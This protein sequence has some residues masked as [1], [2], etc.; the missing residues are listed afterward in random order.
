MVVFARLLVKLTPHRITVV[1]ISL[2]FIFAKGITAY[3]HLGS[4]SIILDV[5]FGLL[6][7]E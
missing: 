4:V 2:V 1:V 5:V 7:L 3:R 6:T